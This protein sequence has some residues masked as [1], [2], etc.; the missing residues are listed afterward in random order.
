ME[1]IVILQFF[2]ATDLE[3]VFDFLNV[4]DET[5]QI[6][7]N[8][9]PLQVPDKDVGSLRLYATSLEYVRLAEDACEMFRIRMIVVN[10]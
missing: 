6:F 10:A 5:D 7:V 9:P 2:S 8:L 3:K 4:E 1:R